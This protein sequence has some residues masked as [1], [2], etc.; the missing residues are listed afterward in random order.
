MQQFS[1]NSNTEEKVLP[2]AIV[3]IIL[4]R[5]SSIIKDQSS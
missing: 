2:A 5:S 4:E 1:K 3:G